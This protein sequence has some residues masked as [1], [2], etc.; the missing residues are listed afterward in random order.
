MDGITL[1]LL[2]DADIESLGLALSN[3]VKLKSLILNL[4]DLNKNVVPGLHLAYSDLESNQQKKVNIF[5]KLKY[6]N[7][8][9]F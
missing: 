5:Y 9:F 3:K 4:K 6:L 7:L 1:K 2:S 8:F